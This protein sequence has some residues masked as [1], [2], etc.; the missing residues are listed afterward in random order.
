[1]GTLSFSRVVG[2]GHD[3]TQPPISCLDAPYFEPYW[4]AAYT[5][6]NHEKRVTS[7][8]LQ[9]S[10]ETFLPLY[11]SVRHWKD[12]HVRLQMPLFPGYVFVRIALRDRLSV[13]QIPGVV[14]LV[15][16]DGHPVPLPVEEVENI[17]ICLERRQPLQPTS[18][19]Q[20]GQRVR[21]LAGPL[22]GLTGAFERSGSGARLVISLELLQRSV[23]VEVD[24]S[25]ISPF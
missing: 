22:A 9:R 15:G 6:A 2:R 25:D 24:A 18:Y 23:A 8:L 12:R 10:V 14:R 17:R 3:Q 4:Y 19:V 5:C 7:Q 13:L 21:V 11:Q 20:Y 1:M 16:F